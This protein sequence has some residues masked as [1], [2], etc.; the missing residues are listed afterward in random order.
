MEEIK[1]GDKIKVMY[2]ID[3]EGEIIKEWGESS[4]KIG[5][6]NNLRKINQFL[7]PF[8]GENREKLLEIGKKTFLVT[9]EM[10][11]GIVDKSKIGAVPLDIM[12][13][14]VNVG[15]SITLDFKDGSKLPAIVKSKNEDTFIVDCN[16]P[17]AGK[18]LNLVIEVLEFI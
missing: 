12:D 11:Y 7:N 2:S 1:I 10:G 4:L 3:T 9:P 17:L 8:I 14:N 15:D 18:D 6:N 5:D 16:H 13:E